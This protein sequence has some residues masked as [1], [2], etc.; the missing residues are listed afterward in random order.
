MHGFL[1]RK[2]GYVRVCIIDARFIQKCS[3]VLYHW[4]T[5]GRTLEIRLFCFLVLRLVDLPI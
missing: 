3:C 2:Y 4:A 5:L 1:S